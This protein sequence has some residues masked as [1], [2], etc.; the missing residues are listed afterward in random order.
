MNA[1]SLRHRVTLQ[2]PSGTRDSSLERTTTWTDVATVSASIE[3]LAG[4]EAFLAAQRQASTTH[5]VTLRHSS[6]LAAMDASWRVV[7]G[8]RVFTLDAPP[9]N[10]DERGRELQLL[11]T[12]GKRRE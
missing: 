1:G 5:L 11:C 6:I 3:P 12:E 9:K 8:D 7:F 10:V 2:R 4:R